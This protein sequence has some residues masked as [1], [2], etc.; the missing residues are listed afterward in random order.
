[1]SVLPSQKL[2]IGELYVSMAVGLI[3]F[4]LPTDLKNQFGTNTT[5]IL[6]VVVLATII[7]AVLFVTIK[8]FE[9]IGAAI[10]T[11]SVI[12]VISF[13][14]SIVNGIFSKNN[15][16]WPTISDY[17]LITMF[18]LWTV[19][20]L[21]SLLVRLFTVGRRDTND[22]RL[23]FTRFLSLSLRAL[24]IIYIVVLIF[25][26]IMPNKPNVVTTR[27]IYYIPFAKISDCLNGVEG[28]TI[29]YLIWNSLILLP[30]TFSLL[31]LNPKMK[32]WYILIIDFAFGLTIEILQFSLNT[33]TVYTDD[34]LLYL[35]GGIVGIII[36]WLIDKIRFI[37]TSGEEP[38]MLSLDYTPVI[39]ETADETENSDE[40]ESSDEIENIETKYITGKSEIIN[41]EGIADITQSIETE[42]PQ[43]E[44]ITE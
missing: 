34:M 5:S 4:L 24:M 44:D 3:L 41:A 20:F 26:Q 12:T 30:L 1:M 6:L 31:I 35:V 7:T 23:G 19:P 36:K 27:A 28:N 38:D 17:Q 14:F 33:A 25:K 2:T 40:T 43:A 42:H 11:K 37:I 29:A 16:Y 9:A 15:D 18:L 10:L 22:F 32:W 8:R 39:Y 21:I 13:G